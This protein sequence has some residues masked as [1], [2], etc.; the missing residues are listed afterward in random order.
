MPCRGVRAPRCPQEARGAYT[1]RMAEELNEQAA[2]REPIREHLRIALARVAAIS[3]E[4]REAEL[5]IVR[6]VAVARR[7][8]AA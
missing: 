8:S 7:R 1:A 2:E 6:E 4:A 5:R 3:P